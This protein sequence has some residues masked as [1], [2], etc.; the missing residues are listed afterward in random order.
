MNVRHGRVLMAAIAQ[1]WSLAT[2]AL[3]RQLTSVTAAPLRIASPTTCVRTVVPVMALG[4]ATV[5][6]DTQVV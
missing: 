1:T 2:T 4:Y 5:H 3:V 6:L